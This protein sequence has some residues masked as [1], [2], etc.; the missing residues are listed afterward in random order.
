MANVDPPQIP[1]LDFLNPLFSYISSSLPPPVYN[2]L[3][4][5]LTHGL[6]FFSA[7]LGLGTALITSNPSDWDAQKIIPPLITLLAAYLALSSAVRTATWFVRTTAW[8]IKWGIIAAAV[9]TALAW[10]AGSGGGAIVP[11]LIGMVSDM[12]KGRWQDA[13]AGASRSSYQRSKPRPRAW[14][15]FEQHREWQFEEDQRNAANSASPAAHVQQ[16]VTGAL[17]RARDGSWLSIAR[18]ALQSSFAD[19]QGGESGD[20]SRAR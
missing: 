7:L 17:N 14:D 11:G 8:L 4:T 9:S 10:G 3:L 6:A 15:S 16:F 2:A 12:L 13:A 19:E 20:D 18:G 5:L 1:F